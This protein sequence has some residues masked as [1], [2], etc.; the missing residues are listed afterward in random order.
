M[1]LGQ[2]N[3][4]N[5]TTSL[6][7]TSGATTA[8]SP[9][10]EVEGPGATAPAAPPNGPPLA[11]VVQVLAANSTAA[12]G[13]EAIDG[14]APGAY[15]AGIQGFSDSGYGV[16][17]DTSTGVD[18]A[19]YGSGRI[20]QYSLT[21]NTGTAVAGP[22]TFTPAQPASNQPGGELM[23]D[24]NGIIWASLPSG[25]AQAAWRRMNTVRFDK[26]DGSNAVFKPVRVVDTRPSGGGVTHQGPYAGPLLGGGT[27]TFP[28]TGTFGIPSDAI[29][30]VGNLTAVAYGS[31]QG[32]LAIFPAGQTYTPGSDP[33]TV[34]YGP[35]SFA[36]ANSFIVGIGSGGAVSVYVYST[37]H[38]IIDIVAY[39]Q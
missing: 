30:V 20:Y 23:R 34:N 15:G 29:G 38:I 14:W 33:S 3:D 13:R 27:Y 28:L 32:Y 26:A 8:P 17:G 9:M 4:A 35:P 16:I 2:A 7:L 19:A 6:S 12:P 18:L 22:P 11:G 24:V 5:S 31:T 1:V 37:Q 25:T 10:F 36:W 21:D 39:I